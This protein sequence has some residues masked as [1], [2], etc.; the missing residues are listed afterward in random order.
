MS[1]GHLNVKSM[2]QECLNDIENIP[3]WVEIL[4]SIEKPNSIIE[5][6][7]FLNLT[8]RS[9]ILNMLGVIAYEYKFY[10]FVLPFLIE[11]LGL[12][13]NDDTLY[14]LSSYLFELNEQELAMNYLNKIKAHTEQSLELLKECK[15]MLSSIVI[16]DETFPN[17]ASGFRIGEYNWYLTRFK[18]AKSYTYLP[19]S[20]FEEYKKEYSREFNELSSRVHLFENGLNYDCDMFYMIFL[21]NA[22][23][24]LPLIELYKKPF[25]FTLYAGGDFFMNDES[26]D[27]K[28]EK[29][30]KSPYLEKIIVN[31]KITKDYL[32][33]KK[34]VT[35]DKIEYIFGV[36]TEIEYWENAD[37]NSTYFGYD[38][39]ILDICF[40]AYKYN[41]KGTNKGYDDF[42]KIS[43]SLLE[44]TQNIRFHVVGGFDEHDIEIE[45]FNENY[46][47]YGRQN[48]EFFLELYKKM[49]IMLSL[50]RPYMLNSGN[51]GGFPTAG[52]VQ[53]A[54]SGVAVFAKDMLNQNEF[55]VDDKDVV[56]LPDD[57]NKIVEKIMRYYENYD[58][59]KKLRQNGKTTFLKLFGNEE[60][61]HRRYKVIKKTL[62]NKE[63]NK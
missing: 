63:K 16:L 58:E 31:Q 47:F 24:F 10:D 39:E 55:L 62:E 42:I 26:S 41:E 48:K 1:Q 35:E 51:F 36:V 57:N 60:Q 54:L 61:M 12:S 29:I 27:L 37:N 56:I 33:K 34:F 13:E 8:D 17:L 19:P 3:L 21:R 50:E 43:Q 15:V 25:I 52:A 9:E 14:N 5:E 2:I 20:L 53:T 45:K 40:I 59:L 28:L 18:N 23:L 7:F 32:L 46:A 11:S 4:N 49:D 44:I 6:L 22:F 30:C 38:K